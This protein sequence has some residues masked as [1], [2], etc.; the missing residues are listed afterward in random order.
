MD[1]GAG[2]ATVHRITKSQTRLCNFQVDNP[3]VRQIVGK[4]H[5]FFPHMCLVLIFGLHRL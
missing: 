3:S 2:Q 1:R 4:F 5:L